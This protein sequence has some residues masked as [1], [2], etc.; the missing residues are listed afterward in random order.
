MTDRIQEH[1]EHAP[2]SIARRIQCPGSWRMELAH[3]QDP[4][5]VEAA[6]G[7]AAHWVKSQFGKLTEEQ[8][9]KWPGLGTLAPN[10]VPVTEE[11]L[12]GAEL[13]WDSVGPQQH[14]E[15]P[16]PPSEY[17]GPRNWGTPDNWSYHKVPIPDTNIIG[18]VIEIADYKFGHR[19]VDVY[20]NWQLLNYAKLIVDALNLDGLQEQHTRIIFKIVQP[21]SYHRDGPVRQWSC[22]AVDIRSEWNLI[23]TAIMQAE[24][25]N[26][27]CFVGPECR[28]CS[29]RAFCPTLQRSTLA[30]IDE[31]GRPTPMSLPPEAL[32]LELRLINRAI[33]RLKARASGLEE[34]AMSTVKSGKLVPGFRT[35]QGLGRVRWKV[36][37][38]EVEALGQ[39]MGV[40]LTEKKAIT[41]KQAITKMGKTMAPVVAEYTET[42]PGELKLVEDDGSL[43]R[44][45]FGNPV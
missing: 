3:P 34:V 18:G 28:D 11:M 17:M 5:G 10:G 6:E 26:A 12:E 24:S 42:P 40:D 2:S 7:T 9:R 41:P 15:E 39:M 30:A 1:A 35:E 16:L 21:R 31:A 45:T 23:K 20:R 37:V 27:Q 36:P 19:Y 4:N 22:M 25:E 44:R 14:D 38:A 43:V 29:A 32:G 13:Y 33:D 8:R